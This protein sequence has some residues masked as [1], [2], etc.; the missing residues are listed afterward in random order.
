MRPDQNV[1]KLLKTSENPRIYMAISASRIFTTLLL[2]LLGTRSASTS[3]S[4]AAI[5][6]KYESDVGSGQTAL[7]GSRNALKLLHESRQVLSP[8]LQTD[9]HYAMTSG[10]H[11]YNQYDFYYWMRQHFQLTLGN[12]KTKCT[13]KDCASWRSIA[14]SSQNYVDRMLSTSK[15]WRYASLTTANG[16]IFP[17]NSIE[18]LHPILVAMLAGIKAESKN[19]PDIMLSQI[20]GSK[21]FSSL[22]HV[23]GIS[24]LVLL[25]RT[26]RK[27][28]SVG[29]VECFSPQESSDANGELARNVK[30]S[31][32]HEP[33]TQCFDRTKFPLL[34]TL[35]IGFSFVQLLLHTRGCLKDDIRFTQSPF[36]FWFLWRI[37][38]WVKQ[39]FRVRLRQRSKQKSKKI[40]KGMRSLH[41]LFGWAMVNFAPGQSP[42][43]CT[44]IREELSS[45][46]CLDYDDQ[47]SIFNMTCSFTWTN[48]TKCLILLKNETFEGNGHVIDLTGV[49]EWEGLFQIA[50]TD[51][52]GPSSLE[53]APVIHHVHMIGGKTSSTGGFIV[54]SFQ[55][56]FVVKNCSSSGVIAGNTTSH[57]SGGICGHRCSGDI[58]ITHCS[59]SGEIQDAAGGIAGREFGYRGGENNVVIISHCYSTGDILG[60]YSGGIC[61]HGT[62]RQNNNMLIIKQCYSEGEI[63]GISSGGIIGGNAGWNGGHV[64]INDCYSRGN[65]TGQDNA[66]GISGKWTATDQGTVTLTNVYASGHIAHANAGGLI[67][68]LAD[69]TGGATEVNISMSVY[70]GKTGSM[71]GHTQGDGAILTKKKVSGNL[72]DIIGTIYCYEGD[73]QE[74]W[75]TEATW[76]AVDDDFPVLLDMPTPLPPSTSPAPTSSASPTPMG[77]HTSTS[78]PSITLP[79][80]PTE[81]ITSSA[82]ASKTSKKTPSPSP[83]PTQKQNR[84]QMEVPVQY[85]RRSVVMG[86]K[87]CT[88]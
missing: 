82:T 63:R 62:G 1:G 58:L 79:P 3:T 76:K 16:N 40:L 4:V 69:A 11:R 27:C 50:G 33:S 17:M 42:F 57:G 2:L 68:H 60:K 83:T 88:K 18:N 70:N 72:A 8:F 85:P 29:S 61:G 26:V 41:L 64:S 22:G 53:D 31:G 59:S 23:P 80:S 9:N 7:K 32:I 10:Q 48:T 21:I 74:C 78:T 56:N 34:A 66:G 81:T 44:N 46:P 25:E 14:W 6:I 65:I 54:Q 71:I 77:T 20:W 52:G 55:S 37:C 73:P 43:A 49:S 87:I 15:R 13:E 38:H 75:D 30:I 86:R 39:L 12:S 35:W 28:S 84:E 45:Y 67:G 47:Y 5:L 36:F 51:D 24:T 19:M